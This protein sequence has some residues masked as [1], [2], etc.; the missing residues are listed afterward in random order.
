M[1]SHAIPLPK[2]ETN[3]S[4]ITVA[5]WLKQPGDAVSAGEVIV[6]VLTDKV[7]IEIVSPASGVLESIDA[8]E[9]DVV[10]EGDVLARIKPHS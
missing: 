5:A 2:I 9:G 3:G 6:E 1:S 8:Q 4:D 7:N 10:R